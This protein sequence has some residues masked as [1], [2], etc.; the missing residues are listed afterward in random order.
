M[1]ARKKIKE[2]NHELQRNSKMILELWGKC[3]NKGWLPSDNI[4]IEMLQKK[5]LELKKRLRLYKTAAGV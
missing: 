2:L 3:Q 4:L 5:Q 1:N